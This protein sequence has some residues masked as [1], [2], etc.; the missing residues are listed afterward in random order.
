MNIVEKIFDGG[1]VNN[2]GIAKFDDSYAIPTGGI[3][4]NNDKIKE[5][6]NKIFNT[7]KPNEQVVKLLNNNELIVSADAVKK[8]IPNLQ[9]LIKLINN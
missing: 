8:F 6:I 5:L 7:I 1:I 2:D 3:V 9:N 4:D